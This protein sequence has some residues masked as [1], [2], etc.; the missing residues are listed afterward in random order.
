[1]QI[2]YDPEIDPEHGFI[3]WILESTMCAEDF[4]AIDQLSRAK[5]GSPLSIHHGDT[6]HKHVA[7]AVEHMTFKNDEET[8]Y[9]LHRCVLLPNWLI[10]APNV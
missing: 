3:L 4:T 2:T 8:L 1:M 7:H 6:I 9:F 10:D 5:T